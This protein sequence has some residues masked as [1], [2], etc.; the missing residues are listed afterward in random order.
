MVGNQNHPHLEYV[1][2]SGGGSKAS[3]RRGE[4]NC[5]KS[6]SHDTNIKIKDSSVY[7]FPSFYM[8]NV[9]PNENRQFYGDDDILKKSEPLVVDDRIFDEMYT[10]ILK[11]GNMKDGVGER[12]RRQR[13]KVDIVKSVTNSDTNKSKNTSNKRK[14]RKRFRITRGSRKR[15]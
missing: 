6:V 1:S 8:S 3:L 10:S 13:T 14:S 4:S 15:K 2:M 11:D 5:L 7:V 9:I 12:K